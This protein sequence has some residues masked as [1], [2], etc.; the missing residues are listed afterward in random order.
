MKKIS[1]ILLVF[2]MF[3]L[4]GCQEKEKPQ[5]TTTAPATPKETAAPAPKQ[6]SGEPIKIGFMICDSL[7][8][9]TAR[10]APIAAHLSEKIGREFIPVYA[11]THE[12]EDLIKN[13][14]VDFFHGNSLLAITFKELYNMKFLTVDKRGRNGH[15]SSG[16][17]IALKDSGIKTYADM[18]DKTMVFG[19]ALAPFGYMAQ[20]DMM[21]RNGIDPEMD[22][23]FYA[24]P[25]GS[26]KHEKVIYGVL[27][28]KY[29]L[30]AAPRIDVDLMAH[31]GKISLDDFVIIDESEIM[32]YCTIGALEHVDEELAQQVKKELM[33]ITDKDYAT[34]DGET[35]NIVK[36]SLIDGFAEAIDSEFDTMREAMKR[37]NMAPY[38][39]Y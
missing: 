35:F 36:V 22:L 1:G 19:P 25:W 38:T 30:G 10:F 27:Y 37:L 16:T 24:I 14:E 11:N 12:F 18:K 26:A 23:A 7:P 39:K 5:T 32:P 20:Y 2:A 6:Y 28:G 8:E 29:D 3:F 33:A 34:V 31:E 4:F 21:K 13:K 15:K 17:I 9:T